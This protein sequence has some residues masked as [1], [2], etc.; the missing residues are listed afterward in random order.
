MTIEQQLLCFK[1]V[2]KANPNVVRCSSIHEARKLLQ[3]FRNGKSKRS[4]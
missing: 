4:D 1:D 2:D 3:E